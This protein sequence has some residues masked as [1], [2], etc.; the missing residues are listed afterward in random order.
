MRAA[1]QDAPET[2]D[3]I[4]FIGSKMFPVLGARSVCLNEERGFEV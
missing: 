2:D 3:P 4:H 1:S